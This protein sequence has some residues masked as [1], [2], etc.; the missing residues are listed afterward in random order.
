M[1]TKYYLAA[2][3]LFGCI[4]NLNA[5][6]NPAGTDSASNRATIPFDS[7][8]SKPP[9]NFIKINITALALNNYSLQYERALTRKISFAVTLRIMPYSGVPL[10]SSLLKTVNGDDNTKQTIEDFRL[11]NTAITPEFRFYL[12]RRGYGRGFY[13][14]PFYR[15]AIFKTNDIDIFYNDSSGAQNTIKLSGKL[16]SNTGGL[17]FGIQYPLG[18][19]II[20]DLQLLGPH[21][22]A[23]KGEFNGRSATPLTNDEQSSI[24]N[25]LDLGIPLINTTTS[26]T[27]NG[28]SLKLNGSWGGIRSGICL[29]VRF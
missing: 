15:Y 11:S 18:R 26:T 14:A 20:L 22:G 10:K 21:F 13:I 19:H 2:L 25:S 24:R 29:G 8:K 12:S 23:A 7:I 27:A 1:K 6:T 28:A 9:L 16:T 5:Q 17:L 4:A 3:L